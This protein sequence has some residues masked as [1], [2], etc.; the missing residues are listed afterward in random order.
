MSTSDQHAM[1]ALRE[2]R[3]SIDNID[4]AIIHMLSERFRCTQRVGA[5]KAE[6]RLPPADPE[7]ETQQVARLRQVAVTARLD[8]DLAEKFLAFI[9]RE[10]I[11]DHEAIPRGSAPMTPTPSSDV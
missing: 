10:V 5:L 3:D 6:H 2:L 11:R 9:V 7:R 8:P 4:S 1:L